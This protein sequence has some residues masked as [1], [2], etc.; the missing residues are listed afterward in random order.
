MK[1]YI[2]QRH[3]PINMSRVLA[4]QLG[5]AGERSV[6]AREMAGIRRR[7]P[8]R[9]TFT[10]KQHRR[11]GRRYTRSQ[12]VRARSRQSQKHSSQFEHRRRSPGRSHGGSV[13]GDA[14]QRQI[15]RREHEVGQGVQRGCTLAGTAA[16]CADV[17]PAV[18]SYHRGIACLAGENGSQHTSQRTG[19]LDRVAG[20][21]DRQVQ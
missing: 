15:D 21:Y 5:S 11:V 19:R 6:E 7:H 8:K 10:T 20:D 3:W 1:F 9:A 18:P 2:L 14:A 12:G 17:E 13:P 4:S 16:S